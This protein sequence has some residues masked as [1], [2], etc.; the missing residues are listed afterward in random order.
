[1]L[2]VADRQTDGRGR[3]GR[4]WLSS[5]DRRSDLF[6]T[7]ALRGQR[8]ATR[9]AIAG[10]RRRGGACA[11]AGQRSAA[12][13]GLKWPNDILFEGGKLGGIL[14]ELESE[15]GVMLAVIGI[16][17]NLQLPPAG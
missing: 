2:L 11:L 15:P 12:E 10:C 5:P 17:L 8:F 16:G 3:R 7:L 1:L 9:G 13:I 4:R 14:V 6:L